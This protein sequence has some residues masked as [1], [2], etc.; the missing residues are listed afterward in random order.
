MR[1]KLLPLAAYSRNISSRNPLQN[2]T[3]ET[4]RNRLSRPNPKITLLQQKLQ[5]AKEEREKA[6]RFN[7]RNEFEK[8]DLQVKRLE[9]QL[10]RMR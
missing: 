9:L 8:L 5:D 1:G 7:N 6:R 4:V 10:S 3:S 2:R